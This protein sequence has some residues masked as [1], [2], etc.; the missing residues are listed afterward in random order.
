[1][2]LLTYDELR[3]E[4]QPTLALTHIGA[5]GDPFRPRPMK[6]YRRADVF[7]PYVGVFAV[8][9]GEVV[10][11]TYVLRFPYR[12][13]DGPGTIGGIAAVSTRADRSRRGLAR[14][15]L[16]EVHRRERE[17]GIGHVALWTNRSWGAHRLY[18]QLGYRD[19]H[20]LTTAVRWVGDAGPHRSRR[21]VRRARATDVD[22]I[23]ELHA[24]V[25]DGR[26]GFTPRPPRTL[27]ADFTVEG[28]DFLRPLW[29]VA[30]G[31]K[32]L[33]YAHIQVTPARARCGELIARTAPAVEALVGHVGRLAKGKWAEFYQSAATDPATLLRRQGYTPLGRSWFVL[34]GASLKGPA[35]ARA[36]IRAFGTNDPRWVCMVGDRF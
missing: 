8:E 26:L 21:T 27:R 13:P 24:A 29:V 25:T 16:T 31:R 34:M 5:F 6:V 20:H 35:E 32:L 30:H 36:L 17:D 28:K 10:G 1:M 3:P 18:E 4:M 19:I 33:G 14:R 2:Q 7:A 15:I 22:A 23:A 11:Q 9:G 12:F